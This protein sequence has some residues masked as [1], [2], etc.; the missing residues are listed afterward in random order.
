MGPISRAMKPVSETPQKPERPPDDIG[1]A[2]IRVKGIT[3]SVPSVQIDGKTVIKTGRWL[4]M[5]GVREEELVEGDTIAD[6]KAFISR[7]KESGL[8]ADLFTFAQRVPDQTAKYDYHIEWENAAVIPI[9]TFS[10]WWRECTEYSIRKAVN[11]S[12]KVGVVVNEVE[13]S[14]A[15]VEAAHSIYN[16][17]PVRQGKAFW[18]YGKDLQTIK[19]ELATYLERSTFIGAY[20][21]GELIGFM[22]LSSVGTTATITQIL[23]S[24]KHFDKRPNNALIATAVEICE[25]QGKSHF[26]YGSFVYYD[27]N[28]T[29]T[30]FK[31][32]NGFTPMDLP[33]Y[34]I[35]LTLK[36]KV[37]LKLGLHRGIAGNLPRPVLGWFLKVRSF[38]YASRRKGRGDS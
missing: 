1:R 34:Y 16:E 5:A 19:R 33:R 36:G 29:L 12:R 8:N 7:L 11:R 35:P 31:R 23:S 25:S 14:D 4:K 2:E 32:R 9:S 30:E 27:P 3:I 38:W 6:P 21:Q 26:I 10:H 20:Y 17:T 28:S 24:I 15:F 18:H 13:F 22:K 37:A